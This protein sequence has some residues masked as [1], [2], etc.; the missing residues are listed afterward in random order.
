LHGP[1]DGRAEHTEPEITRRWLDV[2]MQQI[3]HALLAY[4]DNAR[5]VE[6]FRLYDRQTCAAV[7]MSLQYACPDA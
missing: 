5:A 7:F 2:V 3:V 4:W 1:R 6:Q